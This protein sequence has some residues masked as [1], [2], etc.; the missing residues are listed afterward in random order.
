MK[1]SSIR[2]WLPLSY[3]AIAFFT[4]V[5]LG[6]ILLFALGSYYTVLERRYLQQNAVTVSSV[7]GQVLAVPAAEGL[8]QSQI[9]TLAYLTQTQ[10][11]V[12]DSTG[13][14]VLRSGA[15]ETLQAVTTLSLAVEGEGARQEF[16]Q[17]VEN[18]DG[19]PVYTSLAVIEGEQGRFTS[20][21]TVSGSDVNPTSLEGFATPLL[22]LETPGSYGLGSTGLARSNQVYRQSIEGVYENSPVYYL[23]MSQGPAFGKAVLNTV[24]VGIVLAGGIAVALATAV[25]WRMSRRLNEPIAELVQVTEQMAAGDLSVRTAVTQPDELGQLARSFNTMA[26]RIEETVQTLRNFLSDASH[27]LRTPLTSIRTFIELAEKSNP[28][29]RDLLTAQQQ[30]QQLQKI[31]DDLLDLSRLEAY[32]VIQKKTSVQLRELIHQRSEF[33]AAQAEQA[34]INFSVETLED[35]VVVSGVEEQLRQV[36]DYLLDNAIK[37]TPAHEAITISL[38]QESSWAV[39]QVSDTGVGIDPT[40]QDQIFDRFYRGRAVS[41]YP[42]SGLGLAIAKQIVESH[43]GQITAVSQEKGACFVVRLPLLE[44]ASH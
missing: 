4:A 25:G 14:V 30:T 19:R 18:S 36:V 26:T 5:A 2:W 33:Y 20:E 29:N 41:E 3:G 37:F 39:L 44:A 22:N 17:T 38:K 43:G 40:E 27:E 23:E 32:P 12:T 15:P 8:M 7:L 35:A 10:M 16:S 1:L 21:S 34:D 9:D 13:N 6:G 31:V 11:E 42:G 24:F 28:G